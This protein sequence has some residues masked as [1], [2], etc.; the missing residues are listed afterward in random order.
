M[1]RTERSTEAVPEVPV[2]LWVNGDPVATW[3]CS[4]AALEALGAGRLAALGYLPTPGDLE[5]VVVSPVEG[6]F[7]GIRARVSAAAVTAAMAERE[8]RREHGCGIRFL[9]DCR[10]DLIRRAGDDQGSDDGHGGAVPAIDAFPELFRELFARSPSRRT[11]GGHHTAALS[12]GSTLLHDHEEVG[13][14]N[15]VDKTIGGAILAGDDRSRLG[16]VTTARISAEIAEKAARAGL[17]W[18]ASRSVPTTMA[19]EIA[20]AAEMVVVARAAGKE[21]RVFDAER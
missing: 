2:R 4:P 11:T 16:L 9:L 21:V 18:V 12:D 15:A 5:E 1:D 13:R 17:A 3:T 19:L 7:H 8:H 20:R 14:H 10:P 6:G